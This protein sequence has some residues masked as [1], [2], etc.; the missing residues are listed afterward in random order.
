LIVAKTVADFETTIKNMIAIVLFVLGNCFTADRLCTWLT[1]IEA[2]RATYRH[3]SDLDFR[4]FAHQLTIMENMIQA[5]WRNSRYAKSVQEMD[6]QLL[7][8]SQQQ[9]QI[10]VGNPMTS[11]LHPRV[12]AL[13]L[14]SKRTR[15]D[16]FDETHRRHQQQGNRHQQQENNHQQ[17]TTNF[18]RGRAVTNPRADILFRLPTGIFYRD[19]FPPSVLR[20]APRVN[21]ATNCCRWQISGICIDNCDRK[22][23]HVQLTG[24]NKKAF[25]TFFTEAI[26]DVTS[27][28]PRSSNTSN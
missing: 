8:F 22:D 16:Q 1:H 14:H 17:N 23:A 19:A 7:D 3:C 15:D 6:F 20:K 24:D 21:G 18:I 5:F 25:A 2:N 4:F 11:P 26:R 10:T 28:T 13:F 9:R 27:T 12:A